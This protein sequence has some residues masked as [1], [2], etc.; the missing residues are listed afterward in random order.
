MAEFS[1][2]MLDFI[3]KAV[4]E[5]E[6]RKREKEKEAEEGIKPLIKDFFRVDVKTGTLV[7]PCKTKAIKHRE[8]ETHWMKKLEVAEKELREKGISVEVFDNA[9]GTFMNF[10]S[11]ASGTLRSLNETTGG[12]LVSPL[13]NYANST[14]SFQPRID[15]KLLDTVKNA[16]GKMLEHRGKKEQYEKYARAFSLDCERLIRLGV[17]DVT[18]FGLASDLIPPAPPE[19]EPE[20]TVEEVKPATEQ[21]Q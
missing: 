21:A 16:K 3:V 1:D 8:R 12:A 15:Q 4:E 20:A 10:A 19:P 11:V 5:R 18:Y 6:Q 2:K 9:T 7:D 17:E 13:L 14:Q